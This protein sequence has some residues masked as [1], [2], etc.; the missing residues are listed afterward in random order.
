MQQYQNNNINNVN[1][2]EPK[3]QN[4]VNKFKGP[5]LKEWLVQHSV[6]LKTLKDQFDISNDELIAFRQKIIFRSALTRNRQMLSFGVL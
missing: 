2:T 5:Y 3:M 1:I 4:T 6:S